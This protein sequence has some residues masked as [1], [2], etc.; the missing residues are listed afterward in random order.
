MAEQSP[1]LTDL[2][3]DGARYNDLEDVQEALQQGANIDSRD[4]QGRTGGSEPFESS[5]TTA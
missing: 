4:E 2:L 5:G 1:D 3:V